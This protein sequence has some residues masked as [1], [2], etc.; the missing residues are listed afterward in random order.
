M[1]AI[2]RN[3]LKMTEFRKRFFSPGLKRNMFTGGAQ[4]AANFVHTLETPPCDQCDPNHR[5]NVPPFCTGGLIGPSGFG[6]PGLPFLVSFVLRNSKTNL[7]RRIITLRIRPV[8]VL[9][10][11]G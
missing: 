1:P 4:D 8:G 9:R 11:K 10:R 2:S 5:P 7:K 6:N 3:P